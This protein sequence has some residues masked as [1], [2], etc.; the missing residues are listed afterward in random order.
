MHSRSR[1]QSESCAEAEVA[2]TAELLLAHC[3]VTS[4]GELDVSTV[5]WLSWAGC[6]TLADSANERVRSELDF[7]K[8]SSLSGDGD[9]SRASCCSLW[10]SDDITSEFDCHECISQ[11]A[12]AQPSR[13]VG[14][15]VEC[16][17]LPITDIDHSGDGTQ[18]RAPCATLE[19]QAE[20]ASAS[21]QRS[22][23]DHLLGSPQIAQ[24]SSLRI[25][26][27]EEGETRAHDLRGDALGQLRFLQHFTR[28]SLA[29]KPGCWRA[30]GLRETP[31]WRPVLHPNCGHGVDLSSSGD[32]EK[33]RARAAR[34]FA[35]QREHALLLKR[36]QSGLT[37]MFLDLFCKAGGASEGA[38]RCGVSSVG[39]DHEEQT[40]FVARFGSES[41][42]LSDAQDMERLRDLVRRLKPVLIWA[43]PPCQPYSSAPNLGAPSKAM[44]MIG[45]MRNILISLGVPY[46]IEN[47]LG[48]KS[49]MISPV[50]LWGQLF[51][52]HQR[53][54]RLFETGNGFV[55]R[56][57]QWLLPEGRLL[58]RRSCLGSRRRFP[59]RD[60]FGRTI[61]AQGPRVCCKGNI[62]ATQ[63]THAHAG[64]T[65][66]HAESMGL[67]AGHMTY[68][69]LSQAV[70]PSY[71]QYIV[72]EAV[73][74]ALRTQFGFPVIDF[75]TRVSHPEWAKSMMSMWRRG[76]GGTSPSLGLSFVDAQGGQV[77]PGQRQ[78]MRRR[79][80]SPPTLESSTHESSPS[81]MP[82][83]P[84]PQASPPL[85]GLSSRPPP[86]P[87][88]PPPEDLEVKPSGL[89][90][91]PQVEVRTLAGDVEAWSLCES[92]F[93]ELEYTHAG[94]YSRTVIHPEA[95]N[96][97]A[98]LRTCPRL[99]RARVK[100]DASWGQH[101][102]LVHV[103]GTEEGHTVA[104]LVRVA[105]A[106]GFESGGRVTLIAGSH[107]RAQL[108]AAGFRSVMHWEAG[109]YVL[110]AD[111][112]VARLPRR[113]EAFSAGWREC[114][115][116]SLVMDHSAVARFLD[117]RDSGAPS[118]GKGAKS[119]L[120]WTPL[121]R[122]PERWK[123]KGLPSDVEHMMVHGV[124]I[125]TVGDSSAAPHEV[126]QYA[127]KD[128]EHFVRGA[129]ECDRALL[130]GHLEPVPASEVEASLASGCVHPWTVVHQSADKWRSCQ[131]YK[132]GTNQRVISEL[133]TLCSPHE[134]E[135]VVGPE[136]HFGK[137]DLRDGFWSVPVAPGSRHHLMVRHPATGQLLRCTS[138]P[139][140]YSKSPQHFCRVT[141]AVAGLFRQR[142]AGRGIHVFVF[143]DDYLIVGDTKELT[144][145]GMRI[146]T[147]LLREL[148]LPFSPHKTRG[149][150]RVMEFLGFLLS[151][152]EGSR[153]IAL[154]ESRQQRME[155]LVEEWLEREPAPGQ[156][157]V[158]SDPR[159]LA[160]VLGHFVFASEVIPGGRV[161][162]QAMLRQFKG[163]E[164]DWARGMVRHF[165][166][167]WT[168]IDIHDG[169]W[170]DLRWWRSALKRC[171]CIPFGLPAVGE[172][173]I[174]GTDASDLACGELVWLDGA[175]EETVLHFLHAERRRPIN[176][177]ELRGTLRALE[178]WGSR[179]SGRLVLVE[180]DN[181]VGHEV[182][183]KLRSK[184]E[185]MQ[186]LVRRIHELSIKHNFTIRSVH[187]PG[188]MLVR[189]DQTSRGAAPEEP[190]LRVGRDVFAGI[191]ARFGPFDEFLGTEREL[192]SGG[193]DSARQFSR[194]FA[195]PTYDTVGSTLRII[196]DRLD[197]RVDQCPRGVVV[198]P[199]APE[200]AW[201]KLV[202]QFS[203]VGQWQAGKLALEA[204]CEGEWRRAISQ[205]PTLLLSFPRAGSMLIPL[206][207]AVTMG[208]MERRAV[209][210]AHSA[211]AAMSRAWVNTNS[212]LPPGSLLYSALRLNPT[213]VLA[214]GA[215]GV[216]GCL[217]LTTEAFNG[218]GRLA[219][220]ELLRPTTGPRHIFTLGPSSYER[221]DGKLMPWAPDVGSLWV[222]N[223]LGGRAVSQPARRGAKAIEKYIFDFDRA[224]LEIARA[225]SALAKADAQAE[226]NEAD[227]PPETLTPVVEANVL[228]VGYSL[229]LQSAAVLLLEMCD[230]DGQPAGRF[231]VP[232]GELERGEG[233]AVCACREL[234]EELLGLTGEEAAV[235]G[236]KT[237][238]ENV[239]EGL[240]TGP[241]GNP[242]VSGH[243][244]YVLQVSDIDALCGQFVANDEC[245]SARVVP[246]AGIS[247]N[248]LTALT[249]DGDV[250]SLRDRLG[251]ER[252]KHVRSMLEIQSPP[253]PAAPEQTQ[254]L[255]AATTPSGES[256]EV[257]DGELRPVSGYADRT[258]PAAPEG[259]R[260]QSRRAP[261]SG[262]DDPELDDV[263]RVISPADM[264]QR[265]PVQRRSAPMPAAGVVEPTRCRYGPQKCRGC[266]KEL[267]LD[268]WV[269][270][271][272]AGMVHNSAECYQSATLA[273]AKEAAAEFEGEAARQRA[274]EM[275]TSFVAPPTAILPVDPPGEDP[276]RASTSRE[277]EFLPPAEIPKPTDT[278]QRVV[279]MQENLSDERRELVRACLEGRC[280]HT[281][282]TEQM[283]TC[284]G[285]CGRQIHALSCAQLSKGQAVLAVFQCSEC[286]LR[287]ITGHGPPYT[288]QATKNAEETM[289]CELS[290]GAEKTGAGYAEYVKLEAEWA[291]A[292]FP[293][294]NVR[295][296]SDCVASAK[297]FLTWLVRDKERSRSLTTLWRCM[298]SYMSKT[299]RVNLT[300][301]D[302]GLKAHYSSL[303]EQ[304]G[305]EAHPRTSATPRMLRCAIH[306]GVIEKHCP[307]ALVAA[308]TKLGTGLEAGFGCRVGETLG[309]GDFHGMKAN[310]LRILRNVAT[311]LVTVEGM[312]EHSKTKHKRWL[313]C[314]GVTAGFAELPLAQLTRD[315]WQ[316]AGLKVVGGSSWVE[317]GYEITGV[318][319]TVVR[320]SLLGMTK[321][322]LAVLRK[323]LELSKVDSV[324]RAAKA[325]M[326]RAEDR[327]VAKT[328]KDK[329]YINVHGGPTDDAGIK[330]LMFELT[331]AKLDHFARLTDGPLLR[332]TDGS[333]LSHMPLD[334]SSTYETLHKIMDECFELSNRHGDPDPWLDL[335][336]LEFPLWGHHSWRRM[337]DT[338]ARATMAKSG[339]TEQD[340]DLVFGWLEEMYSQRMQFHYETR[341][342]RDRRY[343]VTMYL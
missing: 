160:S 176:F 223:H 139:F 239:T 147:D 210:E 28:R 319:Y 102:T 208:T 140:G 331:E 162:L 232:G 340:I 3:A 189:P 77:I 80:S 269:I 142:V 126:N 4:F 301:T 90:Y 44:R 263:R 52:V 122:H 151:N 219:C 32:F 224:E 268:A 91:P 78:S 229:R 322:R 69:E 18:C 244:S 242:G 156:P 178:I 265:R 108:E 172:V 14:R 85:L 125:E 228:P 195:H 95:P 227:G 120:A 277:R 285:T 338:V 73:M 249:L 112:S 106:G 27:R 311:G 35:W 335:Q 48:A 150:S 302:G 167:A 243:A 183:R 275:E 1:V 17:S 70:P 50:T 103:P 237:V 341:F 266:W 86:T 270:P 128:K 203:I 286:Y 110:D 43:S 179:L 129:Q 312:L 124:E 94:G 64:T 15:F 309:S 65:A 343:R 11:P 314:L 31:V 234:A 296:P 186:E 241:Y 12:G 283:M 141:E 115:P 209:L 131:D 16:H 264:L 25:D 213:E 66:D 89:S 324:R 121:V 133:F 298:G 188:L 299:G 339:V 316:E 82:S 181:T 42:V 217:Y 254:E 132:L 130:C 7:T 75:E 307:R 9:W 247:G 55:L 205:R 202:R 295:L 207:E 326:K 250:V 321:E 101:N 127:F 161:Y 164:V 58:L 107:W 46:V 273:L 191:E 173:A 192:S 105:R 21:M 236:E 83:P 100:G 214:R 96:W 29:V 306:G 245:A 155:G 88:S 253:P 63:G 274:Q 118:C 169:F 246:V 287:D 6:D 257:D 317:G 315:Y 87:T 334:P 206:R 23:V 305:V 37:P 193:D 184:A 279:Q 159:E 97:T 337:A 19:P 221:V 166:S 20:R 109:S 135:K 310:H 332:S 36:L 293:G 148:G 182:V 143:V 38:R 53:R 271:G 24:V 60:P 54:T 289:L 61:H 325:T 116:G 251:Y 30:G 200:A 68:A 84:A 45:L 292:E 180:T 276:L 284:M 74:H 197:G 225:R 177:R 59:R 278:N 258:P 144:V 47:V 226:E 231:V 113:M 256:V 33:Q 67:D 26:E 51:G 300:S 39:V 272:G 336:G 138:L 342:N 328:S 215:R 174:V 123:G 76:A 291:L 281:G 145:E 149:P 8:S 199:F 117:P 168:Q 99:P 171:N 233:P 267:G 114:P 235:W 252:V 190:R 56:E 165:S 198:V 136:S 158:R 170:R 153:C 218:S 152:V 294:E 308:R 157:P 330:T 211:F 93:R 323:V 119:T 187:T 240:L 304:H 297:L 10:C 280:A 255:A 134:V 313:N 72:G 260:H 57:P 5:S 303:L 288:E 320:V 329:R 137:F 49:S 230:R 185:D 261:N 13:E 79:P 92:D 333:M 22:D 248:R 104:S 175:R 282:S 318:D 220:A 204:S 2:A 201:W 262:G 154:T 194:L 62:W 71:A 290:Q 146:F 163:L 212:P 196:C 222:V 81:S 238:Q 111:R 327:F 34:L 216:S 259:G 98:R 41:F 40:S